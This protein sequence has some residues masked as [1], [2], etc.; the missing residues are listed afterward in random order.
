MF[1][2]YLPVSMYESVK[3]KTIPPASGK[4]LDVDLRIPDAQIK[5]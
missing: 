2:D 1:N 4:I 3:G 5:L